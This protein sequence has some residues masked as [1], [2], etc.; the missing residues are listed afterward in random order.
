MQTLITEKGA[1]APPPPSAPESSPTKDI[2]EIK[3]QH[4][5]CSVPKIAYVNFKSK[6]FSF[7]YEIHLGLSKRFRGPH[8]PQ[9][10]SLEN[11]RSGAMFLAMFQMLYLL[12]RHGTSWFVMLSLSISRLTITLRLLSFFKNTVIVVCLVHSKCHKSHA[13]IQYCKYPSVFDASPFPLKQRQSISHN[14]AFMT[15]S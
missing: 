9:R 3:Y 15:K 7:Q 2:A 5:V 6:M 8:A 13:Y 14:P 12:S 10:A 4:E 11:Q 1:S